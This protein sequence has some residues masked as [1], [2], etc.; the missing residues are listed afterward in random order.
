MSLFCHS[1][2]MGTQGNLTCGVC[3]WSVSS[4]MELCCGMTRNCESQQAS[5][6]DNWKRIGHTSNEKM[7]YQQINV[8]ARQ[9][10]SKACVC[11]TP[12]SFRIDQPLS[13]CCSHNPSPQQDVRVDMCDVHVVVDVCAVTVTVLVVVVVV[14]VMVSAVIVLCV[15]CGCCVS[16]VVCK[17][18]CFALEHDDFV[19]FIH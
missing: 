4:V 13:N 11:G 3:D 16:I 12:L 17:C 10:E 5:R 2:S 15:F 18:D 1:Y 9:T 14:V 7:L 19:A 8:V 6:K